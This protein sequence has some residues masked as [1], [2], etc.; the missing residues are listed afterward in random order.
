MWPLDPDLKP[1]P[2]GICDQDEVHAKMW[3]TPIEL[4]RVG[5]L[6]VSFDDDGKP[7]SWPRDPHVPEQRQNPAELPRHA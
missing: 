5:D 3:K 7:G 1:G 4:I 6:V 2:D